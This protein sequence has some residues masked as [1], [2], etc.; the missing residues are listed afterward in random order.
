MKLRIGY[1]LLP[2][3]LILSSTSP[4]FAADTAPPQL[5]DWSNSGGAD[6]ANS[7]GQVKATFILSD[8]SEIDLPKLLL[9]SLTTSQMTPFATVKVIQKSGKLTSYEATAVVK[10]GQ[11]PKNWEWVL[12]PLSDSLGNQNTQFGP[13]G[14]WVSKV[15]IYNSE[16]TFDIA[17]C[18]VEI[19]KW[20]GIIDQ[21]SAIEKRYSDDIQVSVFRMKST[22][23]LDKRNVSECY[24]QRIAPPN[25][26]L[27]P[28]YN[29]IRHLG[30]ALRD[31]ILA[32]ADGAEARFN[33]KADKAAADKAAADKAAAD[34]AAADKAAAKPLAKEKTIVCTK[35]KTSLKVIGKNPK[36]PPG[37]KVKK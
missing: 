32:L 18:E 30:F 5:V 27:P 23:P 37:Y 11:A 7:D 17:Q 22:F 9:K 10:K 4:A 33:E 24:V 28:I 8:D 14:T 3:A 20:N 21:L 26:W 15:N 34:K 36:C 12:Y 2:L 13:G 1:L 35:G 19:T 25:T 6:I 31:G 29:E 16:Y